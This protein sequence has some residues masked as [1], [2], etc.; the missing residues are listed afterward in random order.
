MD[1]SRLETQLRRTQLQNKDNPLYQLLDQMIKAMAEQG[2]SLNS[3]HGS[4]GNQEVT[5]ITQFLSSLEDGGGGDGGGIP[6]PTGPAGV[7]GARGADG[8]PLAFLQE[9]DEPTPI[10]IPGP[11]GSMGPAGLTELVFLQ[12]IDATG[13]T[14][15][16]FIG[17]I[18]TLYNQYLI[19]FENVLPNTDNVTCSMRVSTDG[20]ATFD[21]GANYKYSYRYM[22]TIAGN[23][24]VGSEV[25]TSFEVC[26]NLD[27]LATGGGLNGW[28]QLFNPLNAAG[29]KSL[30]GNVNFLHND[31][32]FYRT[33]HQ[34]V[35]NP[36]TAINAIR[37]FL[38]SGT[39]AG[40]KFRIYGISTTGASRVTPTIPIYVEEQNDD[41]GIPIPRSLS[42]LG[43]GPFTDKAVLFSRTGLI[44]EDA[45]KILFDYANGF[46]GIGLGA[47]APSEIIHINS[48]TKPGVRFLLGGVFRGFF[49]VDNNSYYTT[50]PS[51][52]FI[53]ATG[54]NFRLGNASGVGEKFYGD[55]TNGRFAIG[56]LSV[57]SA[58]TN[59]LVLLQGTEPS[60]M[61]SNTAGIYTR[62]IN[63]TAQLMAI[64]ENA[65]RVRL[66]GVLARNSAQFDKTNT[67]LADVTGLSLY[68]EAGLAYKF[69]ACL[70]VSASAGGGAKFA[71][72]GG[73]TATSIIYTVEYLD[74]DSNVFTITSKQTALNSPVGQVGTLNGRCIIR[75]TIVVNAAGNLVIQFAQHVASGTSSVLANS[76]Y[77]IEQ[78]T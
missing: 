8:I 1:V 15:V 73:A 57:P 68:V 26:G 29:S 55:L 34:D 20:G 11:S 43:A 10:I 65:D 4:S 54:G 37:F 23:G 19:M 6:G 35:Y 27:S 13:A 74:I 60:T 56:T 75:G 51:G 22:N 9:T 32:H 64:N 36:S 70:F 14:N 58:G 71:V 7:A 76:T 66:T 50:L 44:S 69:E 46:L 21:S 28:Y 40:G 31:T 45:T 61:G 33:D 77:K 49:G 47:T 3:L 59:C 42:G 18:T 39:F 24:V 38:S 5:N 62:D 72:I 17:A 53:I 12:E 25:G 78:V 16:D 63:G 30:I 67:T 2:R 48:A 52:D 41:P